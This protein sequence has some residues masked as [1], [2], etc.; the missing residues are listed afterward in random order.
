MNILY[1]SLRIVPYLFVI[2]I[3]L[4]SCW[5]II[6]LGSVQVSLKRNETHKHE[7]CI[8]SQWRIQIKL[9]YRVKCFT[10]C[11]MMDD[12]KSFR[13]W[14]KLFSMVQHTRFL[15]MCIYNIIKETYTVIHLTH[16]SYWSHHQYAHRHWNLKGSNAFIPVNYFQGKC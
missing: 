11:K 1:A 13:S 10:V 8:S 16:F 4:D 12:T 6:W 7:L 2:F 3:F 14:P 15:F 9:L 5:G